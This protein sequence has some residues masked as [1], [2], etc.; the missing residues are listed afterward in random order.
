MMTSDWLPI[1]WICATTR[2]GRRIAAGQARNNST[3]KVACWPRMRSRSS[4]PAA[5]AGDEDSH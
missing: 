1:A 5:E 4:V 2:Y 3:K